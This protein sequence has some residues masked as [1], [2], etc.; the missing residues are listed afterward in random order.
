MGCLSWAPHSVPLTV[1]WPFTW[2]LQGP[3]KTDSVL[4]Q[5]KP[6]LVIR[7]VRVVLSFVDNVD[8]LP[9]LSNPN[10]K[11][12][13]LVSSYSAQAGPNYRAPN[14]PPLARPTTPLNVP[15]PETAAG[16]QSERNSSTT[17]KLRV[18][19]VVPFTR[20]LAPTP[21]A[22]SRRLDSPEAP[23]RPTI[24]NVLAFWAAADEAKSESRP[25][26]AVVRA[27]FF[28]DGPGGG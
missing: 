13:I 12:V 3:Q 7:N 10:K 23:V 25:T 11:K 1:E 4:G 6:E 14:S 28:V 26:R 15:G 24:S 21:G 17:G 18:S 9:T 27:I 8:R 5:W 19:V 20:A 22:T 16:L 2:A